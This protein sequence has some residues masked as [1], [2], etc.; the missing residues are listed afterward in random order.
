MSFAFVLHKHKAEQ[1]TDLTNKS[2]DK[3]FEIDGS[4]QSQYLVKSKIKKT[5]LTGGL[6]KYNLMLLNN[7]D[8]QDYLSVGGSFQVVDG[9]YFGTGK[10]I[11]KG[12]DSILFE[13]EWELESV[14]E[15]A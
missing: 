7:D 10:I 2:I 3:I 11:Q 6:Y 14:R 12:Q 5:P 9:G 4:L 1:L 8:V 15:K 13:Q